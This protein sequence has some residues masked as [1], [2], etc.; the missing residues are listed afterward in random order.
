[1]RKL[2]FVTIAFF[3]IQ[4]VSAQ[5]TASDKDNLV[6]NSAGLEKKPEYPGG[7]EEF[8][9]FISKNYNTPSESVKGNVYVTFIIEKDGSLSNIKILR[10]PGYGSGEEAKRVLLK[11]PNW[12][13]GE[14]NGQK[15]RCTYSVP[16]SKEMPK[17]IRS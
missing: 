5:E 14:K 9:N 1:M 16:I 7:M 17:E 8:Y 6:Y 13:P 10:D 15:V 4:F 3:A 2:L 12:I 11:C